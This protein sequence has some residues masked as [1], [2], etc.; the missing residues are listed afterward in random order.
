MAHAS[1]KPLHGKDTKETPIPL[2]NPGET[3]HL[4]LNNQWGGP[5]TILQTKLWE[6]RQGHF[7]LQQTEPPLSKENVNEIVQLSYLVTLHKGDAGRVGFSAPLLTIV[8]LPQERGQIMLFSVPSE[9]KPVSLRAYSRIS[10]SPGMTVTSSVQLEGLSLPM[11]AVGDISLGGIRL[12]HKGGLP[13]S[14]GQRLKVS[15]GH[16]TDALLLPATLLRQEKLPNDNY[17]SLVVRF[18]D[19]TSEEQKNLKTVL[20]RIWKQKRM[21]ALTEAS[22]KMLAF[23]GEH[24]SK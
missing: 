17:A 18:V 22:R 20:G 7:L 15:I 6:I 5:N 1:H 2:P 8:D 23:W 11:N 14:E 21:L 24:D 10:P 12:L 13:L 16:A 9:V 19:L 4:V 3:M